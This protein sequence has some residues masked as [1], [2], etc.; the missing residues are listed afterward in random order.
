MRVGAYTLHL[1]C[2]NPDAHKENS[3]KPPFEF[4]GVSENHASLIAM[5]AGW[6]RV[7]GKDLCPK[8]SGKGKLVSEG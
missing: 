1:Y 4:V 6:R 8:C 3:E 2:D 7:K 5:R